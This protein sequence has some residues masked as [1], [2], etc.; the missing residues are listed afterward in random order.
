[1][2]L[3]TLFDALTSNTITIY[4]MY[5]HHKK[6]YLELFAAEIG[7]LDTVKVSIVCCADMGSNP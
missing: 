2:P 3:F 5:Y 6:G 7:Y 1:M 4:T